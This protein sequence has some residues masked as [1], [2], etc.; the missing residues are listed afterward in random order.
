MTDF[1]LHRK[2][3]VDTQVR[4]SDVTKYPI[5]DAML[6]VPR[7]VFVPDELVGAAY[8]GDCLDLGGGRVVLDP[9]ALAKMLDALE[10]GRDDLVLD[11]GAGT[12]YSSALL[13]RMAQTVVALEED[14]GLATEAEAALAKVGAETVV[15]HKAPLSAGATEFAP[16]DVMLTQGGVEQFPQAL[17]DQL[18]EGGRAVCIFMEGAL[19]VVR[20]GVKRDGQL[21]WR[22]I[23]N[24]AA[25]VLPGFRK[26]LEF[27]L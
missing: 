24:A 3:M 7:E 1:A 6:T 4:P 2:M 14:E 27:T 15:V 25:P 10:I 18:A 5:I 11:I 8:V 17:V 21:A 16:F 22:D 26:D 23:F 19:G 13:A 9:R 12:G 20:L